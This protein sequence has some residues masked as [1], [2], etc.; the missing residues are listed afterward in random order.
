MPN[1]KNP[2]T[3]RDH[4]A[5]AELEAA[6]KQKPKKPFRRKTK[7]IISSVG[8][9]F[10][11]RFATVFRC[12]GRMEKRYDRE[13]KEYYRERVFSVELNVDGIDSTV[14]LPATS[15]RDAATFSMDD[16]RDLIERSVS[17]KAETHVM[18]HD[19]YIERI[20]KALTELLDDEKL[21]SAVYLSQ[22]SPTESEDSDRGKR[23]C[24]GYGFP[25][26][27]SHS[28]ITIRSQLSRHYVNFDISFSSFT[29]TPA[30]LLG[31]ARQLE[32]AALHGAQLRTEA[33][34][35]LRA[36][37]EEEVAKRSGVDSYIKD[38]VAQFN[39]I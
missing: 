12:K 36:L 6:K 5:V 22:P 9:E 14:T 10:V 23:I 3:L 33:I 15:V 34:A 38:M 26:E 39:E 19:L 2:T 17:L 37:R 35:K 31:Y 11:G 13:S 24:Y 7:V 18:T 1:L 29:A 4:V 25:S 16:I 27:W 21:E 20:D 28:P 8:H 30:Q 32:A